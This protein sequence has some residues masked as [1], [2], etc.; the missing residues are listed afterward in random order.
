LFFNV[1]NNY[2]GGFRRHLCSVLS[3]NLVSVIFFWIMGSSYHNSCNG[4]NFSY[5]I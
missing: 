1:F 5:S 4:A 3:I 2:C